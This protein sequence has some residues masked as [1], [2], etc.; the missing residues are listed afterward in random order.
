MKKLKVQVSVDNKV[1]FSREDEFPS[2]M[3][4]ARQA[5]EQHVWPRWQDFA[6]MSEGQKGQRNAGTVSVSYECTMDRRRPNRAP[7][8]IAAEK[9]ERDAKRQQRK[10]QHEKCQKDRQQE[11][12]QRRVNLR[13]RIKSQVD[14][15]FAVGKSGTEPAAKYITCHCDAPAVSL[16]LNRAL[17]P[18]ACVLDED[19]I[20]GALCAEHVKSAWRTEMVPCSRLE[21]FY[22]GVRQI[23]IKP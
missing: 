7:D 15:A 11:A 21:F 2:V 1:V 9:A 23:A 17:T 19:T 13:Q 4:E 3:F 8:V 22:D 16:V 14:H 5:M 10:L 6:D 12:E 20:D 18:G